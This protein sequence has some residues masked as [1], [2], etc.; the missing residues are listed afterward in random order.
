MPNSKF[1]MFSV[2]NILILANVFVFLGTKSFVNADLFFGLNGH[3]IHSSLWHQPLTSMFMHAN[4]IHIFM[5]MFVLFQ[6]GNALENIIGKLKFFALYMFGGILT[7]LLT[8]LY[9][10]N[11]AYEHNVVGASGVIC[12]LLGFFSMIEKQSQKAIFIW[13]LLISFGPLLIGQNVAWYGHLAGYLS[14]ILIY[15]V[16]KIFSK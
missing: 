15:F 7:S 6:F 8:F 9:I 2:T 1:E 13:V 12:M 11:F 5:N 10:Q 4:E 14:G 16:S 3:F